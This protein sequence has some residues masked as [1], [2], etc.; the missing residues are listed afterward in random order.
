M[1]IRKTYE[2]M[3]DN[4]GRLYRSK[5]EYENKSTVI[6]ILR[7]DEWKVYGNGSVRCYKCNR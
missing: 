7:D 3:C 2:V 6:A 5:F 1:A 4:C